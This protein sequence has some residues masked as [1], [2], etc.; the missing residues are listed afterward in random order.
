VLLYLVE[1]PWRFAE[2]TSMTRKG[3]EDL[4][5]R[6]RLGRACL[7]LVLV[8]ALLGCASTAPRTREPPDDV[9]DVTDR[10]VCEA[11][12]G[13]TAEPWYGGFKTWREDRGVMSSVHGTLWGH[14][15]R[16]GRATEEEALEDALA[17]AAAGALD[18]LERRGL[19]YRSDRRAE[20]EART[21][22]T[23]L[24]GDEPSFPRVRIGG[25]I[26]EHCR[27]EESG[28]D[29]WRAK[30]LVQ[31][32]IGE[33]RGDVVNATWERE[34]LLREVEVLR[35]SA[36]AHFS[37]GRW[38]DGKLDL[39][40]AKDLLEDTGVS[41]EGTP[42]GSDAGAEWGRPG[43][44]QA[45]RVGWHRREIRNAEA[46]LSIE[47]LGGIE[48]VEIGASAGVEAA[49]LVTCEWE[50]EAIPAVGVPM[51]YAVE[52]GVAAILDGDP[53]TG[54]EGLAR[55]RI[56]RAFGDPG[57]YSLVAQ[58]DADLVRS[59]GV[60]GYRRLMVHA[61]GP[62]GGGTTS[63]HDGPEA[64]QSLFLVTGGHGVTVCA[65]FTAE[66]DRDA[67]QARAGFVQRASNDGYLIEE[68]SHD[69]DVV[70]TAKVR[71]VTV[72][73]PGSWT[74]EVT[75]DGTGFDQR[76][77]REIGATTLTV[78]EV[79]EEGQRDAELLALREAGR[80]LA[81]Y[82]SRRILTSGE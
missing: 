25:K 69:V 37:G 35:T 81:V 33:L 40:R 42:A 5:R 29:T 47:P 56:V 15:G 27:D 7:A 45:E 28:E 10:W 24:R 79:S 18:L 65:Y 71:L 67:S 61:G 48:I 22:E 4:R 3:P 14:G 31:Y 38:L 43:A 19:T 20:I 6:A 75:V 21:V 60:E 70:V 39:E 68:C 50:G 32:P 78:A 73:V 16:Y 54:E 13:T 58:V 36:A 46:P 80:L 62:A 44:A 8:G 2:G 51:R 57:E 59:A 55:C 77:A 17:S 34:R 74:A 52:G 76:I 12:E 53:V 11:S 41:V 30:V 23:L 1:P 26:V 66:R 82:F 9:P 63:Y 64:S 49:F 72:V